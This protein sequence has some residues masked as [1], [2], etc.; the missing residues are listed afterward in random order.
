MLHTELIENGFVY[1]EEMWISKQTGQKV[2]AYDYLPTTKLI[3]SKQSL[4][5]N[6]FRDSVQLTNWI[7]ENGGVLIGPLFS[8]SE[9]TRKAFV[10][11]KENGFDFRVVCRRQNY[12]C[13]F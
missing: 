1:E 5:L 11:G 10:R 9:N 3:Y 7:G 13:W 8:I 6:L 12:F 4:Y 2:F